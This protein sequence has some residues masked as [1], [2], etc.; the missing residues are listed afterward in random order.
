MVHV[1]VHTS[2]LLEVRDKGYSQLDSAQCYVLFLSFQ[3]QECCLTVAL[4]FL[5]LFK[6]ILLRNAVIYLFSF[7]ACFSV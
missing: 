1:S 7:R 3:S 2:S 5:P 4:Q 6:V